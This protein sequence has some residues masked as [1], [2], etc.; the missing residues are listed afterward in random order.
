MVFFEDNLR[1]PLYLLFSLFGNRKKHEKALYDKAT[2]EGGFEPSTFGF[3]NHC[4]TV[5][6]FSSLYLNENKGKKE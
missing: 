5:E 1:F 2:R 6:L 4:S 3:G